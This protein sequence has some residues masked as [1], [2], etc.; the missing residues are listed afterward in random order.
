MSQRGPRHLGDLLQCGDISR[1]KAEAGERRTLAARVRQVLPEAEASHVVSAHIDEA[2]R[3]VV[4]MDS[5]AWAARLRYEQDS[6]LG[7]S[8]KVRVSVPGQVL[9]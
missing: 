1:L 9:P 6:L 7:I 8:L 5:A 4:G 3:L 2:G